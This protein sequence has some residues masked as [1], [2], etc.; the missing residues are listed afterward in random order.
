M[1]QIIYEV[2]DPVAVITLNRPSSL[3]AW[4][5]QMGIEVRDAIERAERDPAVVGIVI[6]GAGRAFCA[7]ADMK[8]LQ[9]ATEGE[10]RD[11]P[12]DD[13][14]PVG[15]DAPDFGGAYTYLLATSKPIIAAINGPVAGMAFPFVLCCDCLL[16][17]SPSPRD[18]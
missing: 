9:A 7:G 5:D 13:A 11:L 4:T 8:V 18:S 15:D 6:T 2:D 16:Y 10:Y 3:N 1:D 14:H 17:T 12:T